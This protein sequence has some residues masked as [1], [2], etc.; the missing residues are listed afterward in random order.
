[1]AA[2]F[3]QRTLSTFTLQ[4][5]IGGSP[6]GVLPG[7]QGQPPGASGSDTP[8]KPQ[9]EDLNVVQSNQLSMPRVNAGGEGAT[10]LPGQRGNANS[11]V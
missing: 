2:M 10:S 4:S 1:M 7:A 9:A 8:Q 5:W 3:F 6:A 11:T